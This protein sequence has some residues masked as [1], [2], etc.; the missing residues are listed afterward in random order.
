MYQHLT[1]Q[2][3][4]IGDHRSLIRSR[5]PF[6]LTSQNARRLVAE[7]LSSKRSAHVVSPVTRERRKRS[8]LLLH[9]FCVLTISGTH[10]L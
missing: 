3:R 2:G 10:V 8:R 5:G 9:F 4:Q 1:H 6:P 7:G